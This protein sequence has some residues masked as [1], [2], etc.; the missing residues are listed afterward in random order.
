MDFMLSKEIIAR[1]I[2][3]AKSYADNA[4]CPYSGVAVGAALLCS[5]NI[6]LGGC[7][8]ETGDYAAPSFGAGDTAIAKAISEGYNQ[9]LALCLYSKDRLVFPNAT[10]RQYL[11][12]FN[13]DIKIIVANDETYQVIDSLGAIYLFPPVTSDGDQTNV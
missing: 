9:M 2:D 5:D 3:T 13:G 12:E 10:T 1:L 6:I 11:C 7:N 4:Y 8:I